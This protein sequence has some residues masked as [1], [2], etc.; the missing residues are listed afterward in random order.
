[1]PE[2]KALI[3]VADDD[4]DIVSFISVNLELEGFEVVKASN[5]AE[6]LDL[7]HALH[8]DLL[9]LDVMMPVMDG[10]QV[11]E[12]LRADVGTRNLPI[13]MLTAKSMSA[14]KVVGL[15]AGADDYMI[16]PFD[17]LELIARVRSTLRRSN[18]MRASNPLTQLPGN[19]Q[20]Q[21]EVARRVSMKVPLALMYIDLDHFKAFN[22]Y[23]GFLRGDEAIQLLAKISG[24]ALRDSSLDSFLGHVGGDDF[25]GMTDP[26]H[27]EPVAQRIIAEW[28][29]E[30][31]A[32][33]EP[34]DAERGYI[35]VPDRQ[36]NLHRM[37]I[38]AVSIG[39]VTNTTRPITSHW[40]ASEIAA[41][42]KHVAKKTQGSTYAVDRRTDSK[43]AGRGE[44]E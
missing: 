28:D 23:Y 34:A 41:E 13:I 29:K 14:D 37:P 5:G 11:C 25:I 42:M 39:I 6:A 7:T 30:I 33:Y 21:E 4:A 12:S 16:K 24:E 3:L 9:L 8:P 38:V 22:D 10:F 2:D 26:E 31:P 17:P 1:M 18:E 44:H 27:A 36:D 35:E 15:T 40:E 32:L 19:V 20:I 43:P